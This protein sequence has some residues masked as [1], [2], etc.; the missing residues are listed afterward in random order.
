MPNFM[1]EI[2]LGNKLVMH[3]IYI[4]HLHTVMFKNCFLKI[5]LSN[6]VLNL[7]IVEIFLYSE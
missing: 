4:M 5:S 7:Q 2:Y 6:D 3:E 1:T